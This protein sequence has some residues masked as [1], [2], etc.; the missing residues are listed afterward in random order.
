MHTPLC[1]HAVGEPTELARQAAK[2][3]LKEIGFSDHSPMSRDDFDDWR[4]K[5]SELEIY[6]EKV[7]QARRDHPGLVI[8]LGLEV[9]YLPGHEEW[10]REL[11]ERCEWDYLIGAVHYVSDSWAIDSPYQLAKWKDRDP[12][13]VWTLYFER[14]TMAAN[15]GLFDIIAHADLCKK[16]CYYPKEDVTGIEMR[17]LDAVKARDLCL[18]LNTAG[19]RKDCKEIYPSSRMVQAAAERRIPIS[20]AS[21]AHA[22]AEVAMNFPEAITLAK[23]A[24]YKHY[25]RF[26]KR[27]RES[28]LLE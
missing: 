25:S 11:S 4:M 12:F 28:V 5:G 7:N 22:P 16:F 17:F 10:I 27:K 14:L 20:F 8:K 18:E 15:S 6:V 21:D 23:G 2:V 19:L 3:G 24:G 13:E 26:S 9:D 1:M